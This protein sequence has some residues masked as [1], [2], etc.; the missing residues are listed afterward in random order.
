MLSLVLQCADAE[1]A[2]EAEHIMIKEECAEEDMWNSEDKLSELK[3]Q[4]SG[5][6]FAH[7]TIS[8]K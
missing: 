5:T 7:H 3:T 6:Y 1:P 2:N 4:T 8:N